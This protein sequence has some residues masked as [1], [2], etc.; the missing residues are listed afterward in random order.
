MK[1]TKN[2]EGFSKNTVGLLIV[3][4]II[5]VITIGYVFDIFDWSKG[6]ITNKPVDV[7]QNNEEVLN[8]E[9]F[10]QNPVEIIRNLL[11]PEELEAEPEITIVN[12]SNNHIKA[13]LFFNP[14]GYYILVTKI[15]EEWIKVLEGNGIPMCS[16]IDQYNFPVDIVSVCID[17]N[18]VPIGNNWE[19]IKSAIIN[20]EVNEVMQ[21]H[22]RHVTANLKNGEQLEGIEPII[23]DIIDLAI[24]VQDNCGKIIMGTE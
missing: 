14:G 9:N 15:N 3:A 17:E 21:T 12:L 1:L 13:N 5:I 18:G 10:P 6:N 24:S 22:S 23:D 8:S 7:N 16:E 4:A 19:L 2:S 20:C 11:T